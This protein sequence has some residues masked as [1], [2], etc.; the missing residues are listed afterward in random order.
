MTKFFELS[1][2]LLMWQMVNP[3]R[4]SS[5]FIVWPTSSHLTISAIVFDFHLKGTFK[6]TFQK[7][8]PVLLH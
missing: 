2:V 4:V 8:N 6:N 5:Y 7:A 3:N 1:D